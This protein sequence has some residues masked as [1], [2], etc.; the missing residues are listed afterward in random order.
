VVVVVDERFKRTGGG[1]VTTVCESKR[2]VP[3]QTPLPVA[4]GR[5][6]ANQSSPVKLEESE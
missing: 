1:P 2:S 5:P 3:S 4:N 6:F